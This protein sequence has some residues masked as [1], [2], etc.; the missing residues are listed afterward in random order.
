MHKEFRAELEMFSF[1][2]EIFTQLNDLD[3]TELFNK[4]AKSSGKTQN[5]GATP[6]LFTQPSFLHSP[7]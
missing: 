4:E 3:L 5:N 2:R 1:P 6:L 7:Q